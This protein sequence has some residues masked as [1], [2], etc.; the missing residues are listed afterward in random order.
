MYFQWRRSPGAQ[1]MFHGAVVEHAARTDARVFKEVAALGEELSS[2]GNETLG[3]R[4]QAEVAIL[5]DWDNWW[6]VEYSSGPH[7]ELRY[8]P[9]VH[10]VF[11]SLWELGI[12]A[13]VISPSADLSGYKVVIAPLLKMVKPGTADKLKAFAS[14]GGTV[15]STYFSGVVDETDRAFSNGYPGPLADLFGIWVEEI[16]S[17]APG[18]DNSAVFT[19]GKQVECGFLCD[20]IVLEGATAWAH[21]GHDFYAGK[22]VVTAHSYGAGKAV[23]IGSQLAPDG[24]SYL[25]DRISTDAKVSLPL[26]YRPPQGVEVQVRKTASSTLHYVLNHSTED[27]RVALPAGTYVDLLT[28]LPAGVTLDLPPL[29]VAILKSE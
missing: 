12:T 18:E 2:L 10:R 4:V 15:V 6:A 26:G 7:A 3:G 19:D 1:E 28:G 27:R 24:L 5:F 23:Y 8:V 25:L 11:K 13:D 22:P 17:Q 14:A 20:Q 21:Y 29:A 16:D 9:E